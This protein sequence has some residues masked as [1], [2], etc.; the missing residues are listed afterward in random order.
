MNEFKHSLSKTITWFS[1]AIC[2]K[3][4]TIGLVIASCG[5]WYMLWY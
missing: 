3:M 5:C 1:D 4:V 2:R